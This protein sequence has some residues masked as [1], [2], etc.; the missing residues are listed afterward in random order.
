MVSLW[1]DLLLLMRIFYTRVSTLEQTDQRQLNDAEKFDYI[2]R[3][4][5]SRLMPFWERPGGKQIKKLKELHIH[6]MDRLGRNTVDVLTRW[7]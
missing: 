5:T 6:S 3:D 7:E 2:I 4:K 1:S